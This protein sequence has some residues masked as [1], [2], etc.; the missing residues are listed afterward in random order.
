MVKVKRYSLIVDWGFT[1]FKIWL[2]DPHG[3]LVE[4]AFIYTSEFCVSNVVFSNSDIQKLSNYLVSFLDN[5]KSKVHLSIYSSSQMHCVGVFTPGV[6]SVLSTWNDLPFPQ[7]VNKEIS[8]INGIP[9][10]S[11]MPLFKINLDSLPPSLHQ[12]D[13]SLL[14]IEYFASP[15]ALLFTKIFRTK[16]PCSMSWWQSTCLPS[17]L[18]STSSNC[19][20]YLSEKP[21]NLSA[22]SVGFVHP[23]IDTVQYFPEIG[24]LQASCFASCQNHDII[25]NLGTGSQVIVCNQKI[26]VSTP[27]YRYWPGENNKYSV[28]SHI[29]CGRLLQ[30]YIDK[31]QLSFD[32]LY[33]ILASLSVDKIIANVNQYFQSILFFPGYCAFYGKYI[34]SPVVSID[35]LVAV[36]VDV[37]LSLWIFQYLQIIKSLLGA[38]SF[39]SEVISI[40][41]TGSLGGLSVPFITLLAQLLPSSFSVNCETLEL[42]KSLMRIFVDEDVV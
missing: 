39:N 28:I 22:N 34:Q 9:S 10:L 29:P 4:N 40:V 41:V 26:S 12:S 5:L 38:S 23:L 11:S 3:K 18:L 20:S 8:S 31:K 1:R 42:P 14:P 7:R 32:A 37:L 2:Y 36:D 6:G 24:D 25:I 21:L 35:K 17:E 16:L 27:F 19:G 33:N 30:Q 15:V 13:D